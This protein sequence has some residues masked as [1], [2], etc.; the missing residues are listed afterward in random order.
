MDI[1]RKGSPSSLPSQCSLAARV[2]GR[3]SRR[4]PFLI[5]PG[6]LAHNFQIK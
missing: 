3:G 1:L 4:T 5:L 2:R 6:L